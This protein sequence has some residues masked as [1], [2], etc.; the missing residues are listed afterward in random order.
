MRLTDADRAR[1]TAQDLVEL[2]VTYEEKLKAWEAVAPAVAGLREAVGTALAEAG[3]LICEADRGTV[4]AKR[5]R[6]H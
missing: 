3:E 6:V 5:A 1:E 4:P 2:L